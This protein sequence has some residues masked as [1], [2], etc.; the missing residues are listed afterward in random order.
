MVWKNFNPDSSYEFGIIACG[1]GY[2]YV[3][4]CDTDDS[5]VPVL[6]SITIS[7]TGRRDSEDG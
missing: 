6:K 5:P 3:K 4:E 2:N 1:I 7:F